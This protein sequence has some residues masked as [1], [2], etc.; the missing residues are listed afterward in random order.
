MLQRLFSSCDKPVLFFLLFSRFFFQLT[1]KGKRTPDHKLAEKFRRLHIVSWFAIV[2]HE[3]GPQIFNLKT[4]GLLWQTAL[5]TI[6][7][8]R[9]PLR[10]HQIGYCPYA[11]TRRGLSSNVTS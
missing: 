1:G 9:H 7:M 5:D 8:S 11:Y 10:V 3:A 6:E 2:C 4:C